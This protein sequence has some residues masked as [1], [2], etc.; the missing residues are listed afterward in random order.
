MPRCLGDK[1]QSLW[2]ILLYHIEVRQT[3][4]KTA[5]MK[6]VFVFLDLLCICLLLSASAQ[7]KP[8]PL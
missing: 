1:F 2:Y 3:A 8:Q 6:A 7:T 4:E 5:S